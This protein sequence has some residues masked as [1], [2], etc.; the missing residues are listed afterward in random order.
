METELLDAAVLQLQD[1]LLDAAL[2][3][4]QNELSAGEN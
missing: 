1:E 2:A 3:Q 4:L